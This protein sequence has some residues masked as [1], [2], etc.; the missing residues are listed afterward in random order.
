MK[1]CIWP[2]IS[3]SP[4]ITTSKPKEKFVLTKSLDFFVLDLSTSKGFGTKLSLGL[5]CL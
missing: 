3:S 5:S 4:K 2:N 1:V